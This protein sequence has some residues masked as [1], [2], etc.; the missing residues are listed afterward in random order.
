MYCTTWGFHVLPCKYF[1]HYLILRRFLWALQY[2]MTEIWLVRV[3][4]HE[5]PHFIAERPK[6]KRLIRKCRNRLIGVVTP[7]IQERVTLLQ[8]IVSQ[9]KLLSEM[10]G[11]SPFFWYIYQVVVGLRMV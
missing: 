7:G 5:M 3:M 11:S 10:L 6:K 4:V 2:N 1:T 9:Y 8:P